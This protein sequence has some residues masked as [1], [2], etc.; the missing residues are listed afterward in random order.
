MNIPTFAKNPH[1]VERPFTERPSTVF[2]IIRE[3][4]VGAELPADLC[5]FVLCAFC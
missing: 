2:P 3:H 4:T 5:V 1:A